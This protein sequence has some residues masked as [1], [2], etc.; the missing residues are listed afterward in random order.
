VRKTGDGRGKGRMKEMK[1]E[2]E[3]ASSNPTLKGRRSHGMLPPGDMS[4]WRA[5]QSYRCK[6]GNRR[7]TLFLPSPSHAI[8]VL[9]SKCLVRPHAKWSRMPSAPQTRT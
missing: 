3:A 1:E 7:L 8:P 9:L 5:P 6:P 2:E 4:H